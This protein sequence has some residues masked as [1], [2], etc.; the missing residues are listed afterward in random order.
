MAARKSREETE[1]GVREGQTGPEPQHEGSVMLLFLTA[2]SLLYLGLGCYFR[3]WQQV[4]TQWPNVLRPPFPKLIDS[5]CRT[6]DAHKV[7]Q[8]QALGDEQLAILPRLPHIWSKMNSI[9]GK[10]RIL[11]SGKHW[12]IQI[13]E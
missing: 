7:H 1:R 11:H 3:Q 13:G 4:M 5:T 9:R 8:L 2:P 10:R 12:E 6:E